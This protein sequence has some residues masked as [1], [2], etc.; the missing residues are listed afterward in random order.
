M[1]SVRYF[2]A[3]GL[4]RPPIE[5]DLDEPPPCLFC[6]APVTRPSMDGPLV[7]GSCDCGCNRDGT[8]WTQKQAD[9]RWA[10]R[11]A[12]IVEYRSLMID[13]QLSAA[14]DLLAKDG[15]DVT[16]A[17]RKILLNLIELCDELRAEN[18]EW[19]RRAVGDA[20][21][22]PQTITIGNHAPFSAAVTA[23]DR[24]RTALRAAIIGQRP[25]DLRELRA[26][27][28]DPRRFGGGLRQ[29][30]YEHSALAML[31]AAL[32]DFLAFC[33]EVEKLAAEEPF[34]TYEN[35]VKVET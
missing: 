11:R 7:C 14:K 12:K 20:A 22:W 31:L 33:D 6:A 9:D 13:R 5:V 24:L 28:N 29:A 35:S 8:K 16:T 21:A 1:G 17:P 23:A 25:K 3:Q 2:I 34:V 26:L 18:D 10:H 15:A 4:A 32:P 19:R 30:D 27:P